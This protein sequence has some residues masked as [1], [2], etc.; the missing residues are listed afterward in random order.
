MANR[1][2]IIEISDQ[3]E[4]ICNDYFLDKHFEGNNRFY[5][6]KVPYRRNTKD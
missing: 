2:S 6:F 4:L 5:Q 1:R 3:Q